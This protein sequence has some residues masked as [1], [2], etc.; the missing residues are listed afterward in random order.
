MAKIVFILAEQADWEIAPGIVKLYT[1]FCS[2]EN[3]E[4]PI[5]CGLISRRFYWMFAIG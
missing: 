4:G 5:Q 1:T 3:A 2:I